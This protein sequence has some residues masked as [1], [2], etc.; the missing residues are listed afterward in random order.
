M[1]YLLGKIFNGK[2]LKYSSYFLKHYGS[3]QQVAE[4]RFTFI[5]YLV[6]F[7]HSLYSFVES[8][9]IVYTSRMYLFYLC[10]RLLEE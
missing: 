4:L 8:Y 5:C 1:A 9:H 7:F 2:I 6:V 10:P 3:A